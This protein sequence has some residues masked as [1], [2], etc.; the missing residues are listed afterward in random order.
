MLNRIFALCVVALLA[1]APAALADTPS[2][3]ITSPS[4]PVHTFWGATM[5]VGDQITVQGTAT[6]A[7]S[8]D[9]LCYPGS[10]FTPTSYA[11]DVPV[12][13]GNFSKTVDLT[14]GSEGCI[15]H[16]V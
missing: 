7:T 15:L 10:G 16:A 2:S 13:G 3:Q 6:G 8:V 4:D 14:G 9:L 12:T 5:A 11:N 1:F